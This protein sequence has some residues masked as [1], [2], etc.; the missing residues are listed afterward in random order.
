MRRLRPLPLALTGLLAACVSAPP[1]SPH[2]APDIAPPQGTPQVGDIDHPVA[3]AAVAAPVANNVW[4]R[5]RNSFAMDDCDADPAIVDAARKF[6]SNPQRFQ[7]QLND[8]LPHL[9]YVEQIAA[10]HQVAG[11]FVL[12]PWVE[13]HY[14]PVPGHK[15][16]PAGMWQIMP[17]TARALGMRMDKRYDGRLDASQATDKI[18][19][20]LRRY[21]DD[22]GDWRMVDYAYNAGEFSVRN[23][24]GKYGM[25]PA[26]PAIPR[27]PVK[28]I[29]REHLVKLLAMACVVREPDRFQVSLPTLTSDQRLVKVEVDKAMPMAQAA[30]HAGMSVSDFKFLN[31]GFRSDTIDPNLASYL[32]LP[33]GKAEQFRQTATQSAT[34]S[35]ADMSLVPAE[36]APLAAADDQPARSASKGAT[37]KVKSGDT[38]SAIAR[39]HGVT[40]KQL[41][42]WNHLSGARLKPG[43]TIAINGG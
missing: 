24:I 30:S 17:A 27:M 28:R 31:P 16:N 38:L 8:V 14:R 19:A 42:R 35:L 32:L 41:Q 2:S 29:T 25:P 37:Y 20:L 4:D 3:P 18:M 40:I 11:E 10:K 21:H 12:L 7:E 23:L 6:T 9:V 5:L 36:G 33:S 22:L 43:Q 13:S 39:Q 1:K 26:D 15:N 34:A